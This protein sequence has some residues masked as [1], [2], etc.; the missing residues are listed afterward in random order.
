[1]LYL[2]TNRAH[3]AFMISTEAPGALT[4]HSQGNSDMQLEAAWVDT[5][6]GYQVEVSLPPNVERIGV[7]AVAPAFT[8]PG[9]SAERYAGT[10]NGRR[11]G[12]WL[13]L[14]GLGDGMTRW[15][16]MAV[17]DGSRAWLVQADGWGHGGFR[18]DP[19]RKRQRIDLGAAHDLP[20][21]LR[22]RVCGPVKAGPPG[23]SVLNLKRSG[24]PSKVKMANNGVAT[25]KAPPSTTW[26]RCR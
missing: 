20:R 5:A 18:R 24:M 26:S 1:M 11:E 9:I 6:A 10:L 7:G 2:Q 19:G 25:P 12:D 4:L 16:E 22:I 14:A 23:P 8:M 13:E 15:L 3:H 17:A 21:G